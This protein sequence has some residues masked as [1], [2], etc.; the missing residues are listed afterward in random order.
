MAQVHFITPTDLPLDAF[1]NFGINHKP[2]S[3]SPIGYFGTGLKYVVAIVARHGGT[4]SLNTPK[5]EFVFYG[6]DK[7][8]RGKTFT[9]L[10]MKRRNGWASKWRYEQMPFTTELGKNWHLWQAFRELLS[11][12]ID[13][14]GIVTTDD[15]HE[16]GWSTFS[17]V[18]VECDGFDRWCDPAHSEEVWLDRDLWAEPNKVI[19]DVEIWD[20]PAICVYYKGIR[21]FDFPEGYKSRRTYN[22]TSGIELSEDRTVRNQW[23]MQKTLIGV[24][25]QLD[26]RTV[27]EVLRVIPGDFGWECAYLPLQLTDT[28]TDPE[29]GNLARGLLVGKSQGYS[30][31]YYGTTALKSIEATPAQGEHTVSVTLAN[32]QWR[33]ALNAMATAKAG[34]KPDNGQVEAF[35]A[36]YD[37]LVE[38]IRQ[39][40]NHAE[41]VLK[42]L[43]DDYP[44]DEDEG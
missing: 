14:G 8:F 1:T 11:N 6:A 33:D 24:L 43:H 20:A 23:L 15:Y 28:T 27:A 9:G 39:S 42:G 40:C 26:A 16:H 31:G 2:N 4:V 18:T 25:D 35:C 29:R 41:M 32:G 12:T 21:V 7:E 17:R 38:D 3:D 36:L 10:R 5:G 30:F 19:D 44:E 22:F 37:V 34:G 13:E